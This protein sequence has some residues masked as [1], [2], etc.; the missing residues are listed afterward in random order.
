M[1]VSNVFSSPKSYGRESSRIES[2]RL[3]KNQSTA[4]VRTD[5]K[6]KSIDT[7][8]L[9]T[10]LSIQE[11][12]SL[13]TTEIGKKL[14]AMF[15]R[16]G[17]DPLAMA[18]VDWSPEAT[19]GRIFDMTTSLYEVWKEQHKGASDEELID[20]FEKTIR[21]AVDQGASEAME[22]IS[23]LDVDDSIKATAAETM[24]IL[25]SRYDD[26]FSKLRAALPSQEASSEAQAS[27]DLQA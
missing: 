12:Q 3:Q 5:E 27:I 15:S 4:E 17:L 1:T 13:L 21:K 16:Y 9:K 25:H 26:F 19:A 23:A 10:G 11:I 14:E 18:G 22:I 8:D 24:S 6:T 2:A 20:G 7:V